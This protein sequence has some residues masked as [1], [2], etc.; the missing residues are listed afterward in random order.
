MLLLNDNKAAEYGIITRSEKG[1]PLTHQ[2]LD[3]NI[4]TS[5]DVMMFDNI[6]YSSFHE[7][8]A[9]LAAPTLSDQE[10]SVSIH[11]KNGYVA[12]KLDNS[13]V[14]ASISIAN[15]IDPNVWIYNYDFTSYREVENLS[16]FYVSD[17]DNVLVFEHEGIDEIQIDVAN[18]YA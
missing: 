9:I 18:P 11:G 5:L 10:T 7:Y 8:P 4:Q 2:E 3:V 14:G 12:I 17:S 6:S 16:Q 13:I 1:Y 15:G